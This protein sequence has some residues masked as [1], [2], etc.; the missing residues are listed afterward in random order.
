M[1]STSNNFGNFAD[2]TRMDEGTRAQA[3][4][5]SCRHHIDWVID[6]GS[7]KY[8][9]GMSSSF[10]TYSPYTHSESIQIDDGTSQL[11]HGVGSLECTPSLSLSSV[12]HAP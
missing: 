7:S 8:V 1:T 2:Y 11:I 12:L 10:K 9:T 5:S 3:L 4:A 6:L